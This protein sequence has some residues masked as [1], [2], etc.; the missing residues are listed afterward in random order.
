MRDVLSWSFPIGQLFGIVIK[1]HLILPL[2]MIGMIGR[3]GMDK[4]AYP[5]TWLDASIVMGMIF[6][7]VLLHEFGHC[8]AARYMDGESDE[9]LLW[10]LGGLAF[11]R[12]LPHTPLANFVFALG[13]PLVNLLLCVIA[14]LMLSLGLDQHFQ[15]QFNPI[16]YPYRW[17]ASGAVG[18]AVWGGPAVA[19]TANN[20]LAIN[21]Q[22]LF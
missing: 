21:L 22:R 17:D 18:V 3:A 12:T 13:G 5:G 2:F 20:L 14:G 4:N 11:C 19:E 8:F 10:P 1:V 15:P 16:W 9:V 7:T 6:V